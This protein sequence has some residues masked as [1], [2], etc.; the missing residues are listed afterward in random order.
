MSMPYVKDVAALFRS[1]MDEP[2]QSF[3]NAAQS[4]LYLASGES[5]FRMRVT[6]L[7]PEFFAIRVLL[8]FGSNDVYDLSASGNAVRLLGDGVAP[9]TLTGPRLA[10]IASLSLPIDGG[11]ARLGLPLSPAGS[12]QLLTIDSGGVQ[13]GV[14]STSS[15]YYFNGRE[16]HTRG[17][18]TQLVLSYV[19]I[20]SVDWTAQDPSDLEFVSDLVDFHDIIAL[21]AHSHYAIRDGD[22]NAVL[23]DVLARRMADLER[24][25]NRRVA[26]AGH[27]IE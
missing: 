1:Y 20:S 13:P 8:N 21:L 19:P 5:E 27:Y 6:D 4:A 25:I 16:I 22:P 24:H 26:E 7:N 2:D 17:T 15:A 11:T 18:H 23:Q 9:A 12:M 14:S 10:R 3:V